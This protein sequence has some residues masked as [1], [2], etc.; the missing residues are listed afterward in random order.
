MDGSKSRR[1]R[2]TNEFFFFRIRVSVEKANVQQKHA[3]R[4]RDGAVSL[5]LSFVYSNIQES[6]DKLINEKSASVQSAVGGDTLYRERE[7]GNG[8]SWLVGRRDG[9]GGGGAVGGAGEARAAEE[10]ST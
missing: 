8:W 7:G 4:S 9:V 2:Y 10:V 5:E 1:R 6:I 3:H